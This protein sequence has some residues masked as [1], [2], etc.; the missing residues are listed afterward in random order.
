MKVANL[1]KFGFVV[2]TAAFLVGCATP[3]SQMAMSLD[4]TDIVVK[5]SEK[6]KGQIYVRSV[7]GGKETNPAWISNIN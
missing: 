3:A 1:I 6:L 4:Q 5:P 2:A 7:K